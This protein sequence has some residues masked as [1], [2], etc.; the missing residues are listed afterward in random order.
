MSP[1]ATTDGGPDAAPHPGPLAV[2]LPLA[3]ADAIARQATDELP[4]EACG[5]IVGRGDPRSGGEALRYVP[6]R[7][8]RASATRFE[9]HPADVMRLVSATEAAGESFW[10][11]VH[12]HVRRPAVPSARDVETA[13]FWPA[14]LFLLVSAN[15][16]HADPQTGRLELRAWRVLDGIA[17][18]V[19]IRLDAQ[20]AGPVHER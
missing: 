11:I 9:I 14:T 16:E 2:V 4:N 8:A 13:A 18:E 19:A 5:V 1:A 20:P 17:H 15:P 12:S 7:N 10:G 6:C 3:I